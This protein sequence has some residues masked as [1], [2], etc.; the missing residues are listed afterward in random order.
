M[1]EEGVG[2][3]GF[4]NL[5]LELQGVGRQ[6]FERGKGPSRRKGSSQK[7]RLRADYK[8]TRVP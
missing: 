1:T 4:G 8:R 3:V 7:S 2:K 5:E 6:D